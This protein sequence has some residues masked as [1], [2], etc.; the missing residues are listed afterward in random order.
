[1]AYDIII[2]RSAKDKE[3]F[4][5][6]GSVFLGRHYVK[7]GQ[8]TSLSNEIFMDVI[9]SHVVFVCG[10]R[11]GGKCLHGDTLITLEDGSQMPIKDAEKNNRGIFSLNADFRIQPAI[12]SHF[13]KREVQRLV[14]IGLRS[15]K[16]IRLTPEHPLL[17]VKGWM[18]AEQLHMGS[19]I[20][21]PRKLEA[22]GRSDLPE[23]RLKLLAYLTT[24]GHLGNHFVL[25]SNADPVILEDFKSAVHGFDK[26]LQVKVHG[27]EGCWRVIEGKKRVVLRQAERDGYGRFIGKP[28]ISDTRSSLRKWLEDIGMYGKLSYERTL[29]E[30]AFTLPRNKTALL[31]NRLFSCDG[32][33]YKEGQAYWK[34]AYGSS[35]FMLARQVQHLLLKFGIVSVLRKKPTKRRDAYEITIRGEFVHTFLDQIGFFGVKEKKAADAMQQVPQIIRNPNL[36][37]IPKELWELYHPDSWAEIGRRLHY[38]HPKSMREAT[39]YSPSRQK[40]LQI[41]R[42]DENELLQKLA[43]S[44]IFWDEIVAMEMEEGNFTV[45][46]ISVPEHHNFVAGDIIVHN[47]Y[48]MGVIAEGMADLPQDIFQNMAVVMLDTMGI[49]WTMKYPNDKDADILKEWKLE[50]KPLN[51]VLYTPVGYYHRYKEEGIPTDFPFSI[52]PSDLSP[53]DWALTFG[54]S[55]NDSMGVV[56]EKVVEDLKQKEPDFTMDDVIEAVKGIEHTSE[57]I[58]FGVI[59]RFIMAKNWGIFSE[60]GTRIE[61]IVKSGQVTVVDVSCYAVTPGAE[62]LRALVIGLIS[63]KLFIQRMIARKAEEHKAIKIETHF[64]SEQEQTGKQ[65]NPLVWLIVDEAHEFLPRDEKTAATDALITILREGRQP[66]IS[67]ILASQQPGKIHTDVMTQSDIVI[68]HRITAKVDTDAL[69][70]LMQSYMREGLDVQLNNLP[71]TTGSALVFDDTNERIYPMQIRPRFTWHGGEAPVAIHEKKK[72]FDF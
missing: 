59:N 22:F 15:G 5:K 32:T 39:R 63:Q 44:D 7:M 48:T 37:T 70:M 53:Y 38:S 27:K 34:V 20:A 36:D 12:K 35:S 10:K 65:E 42:A 49:Y 19:R 9:R 47:S 52:K 18:P 3:K 25:F 2:G 60:N 31:L 46:D 64:M 26:V 57:D 16:E 41:A 13:Y 4:G 6:E 56:I 54:I 67:L 68:S 29:P 11:G 66:G 72:L 50:G 69:G 33:I 30:M 14:R 45:Y 23:C 24:E 1:M 51:V 43:T 61:D 40:L 58:K 17:T 28:E 71:R 8:T 62:G 21:T 55:L